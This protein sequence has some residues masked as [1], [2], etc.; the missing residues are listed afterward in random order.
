MSSENEIPNEF[1]CP[2]TLEIMKEPMVMPDGH[3]Y[4][5]EAIKKALEVTHVSPLTKIPMNF[6]DGVINYSLKSLIECYVKEHNI[7]LTDINEKIKNLSFSN[8]RE[9]E[10]IEFE[11]LFSRIITK[12]KSSGL[13][14]DSLHV[15]MKPKK[16]RTTSPVCLI[17]VVDISGSMQANCCNNVKNMENQYISRLELIK[18]SLKTI[19]ASL[20]K[21]DMFSVITFNG[22]SHI[23][24]K[25]TVLIDKNAKESVINDINSMRAFGSTNIWCGIKEAI[26]VS[27][28]I[29]FKNYRKSIM[30]FTDGDSNYNPPNGV[31]Q[32]LKDTLKIC[33]DNFTISTFS[34][35]NDAGPELLIDIANLGN[36]I[37]G[38]CSDGTMV[39]TIFINYMANLLSTITPIVKVNVTQGNDVKKT[40]TIGP[41]YR[42]TY[43]NAIF[44]IDKKLLD[45]TKVKVELPMN[46]QIIEV[47]IIKESSDL[48]LYMDEMS[49]KESKNK[50]IDNNELYSDSDSDD[51][52][53]D[54]DDS[55]PEINNA[56]ENIE[57]VNT[58]VIIEETGSEPIKYEEQLLNQILRNK[59]VIVLNKIIKLKNISYDEEE[60][61]KAKKL[62]DEYVTIIT[63][64]K[65][66]TKYAKNLL[67]DITNPDP[68]HGQV[69]KAISKIYYDTWGK[70]YINSFLRFHQY[71]QCG[72][73]KDQSLQYYS[74]EV[75]KSYRKM[76][77]TLFV[78]LPPPQTENVRLN[79]DVYDNSSMSTNTSQSRMS[80][81]SLGNSSYRSPPKSSG[82]SYSLF[83]N[84]SRSGNGLLSSHL[85]DLEE[86]IMSS[87]TDDVV[88]SCSV[89]ETQRKKGN[90]K[91]KYFINRHGGCFNG[92]SIVLLAN[93]QS[94]RVKDLKKGDR[95]NN[96]AIV[97]CLIEQTC[98]KLWKPYMCDI[99]G[100]L[101]T[102]YHPIAIDNTWYFPY[103]L[104]KSKEVT[105]DSWYNLI[106]QDDINQKYEIEF[107]NGIKAI[108]LGHNRKE[109][110]ILKHPYFGSELVL[111]DLQ[112]R[113]PIGYFKGYILI[114]EFN[115][116]NLEYD[117]NQNCINYYK[118]QNVNNDFIVI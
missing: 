71:E 35:G 13:C 28:S 38:Y 111:K 87:V 49:E 6:S 18:H 76:A 40:M 61:K 83:C 79:Y 17:C 101:F 4:E 118:I 32:T 3:T 43:R 19:V 88:D 63:D 81:R 53:L 112:E 58:D 50:I 100:V 54:S 86:P 73:F 60:N 1:I 91:M 31:Y 2:I 41:L 104:V 113:D 36:G 70:C 106:L 11:E 33:K 21:E 110:S 46:N 90:V 48:K 59:F 66:K 22:E 107:C 84:S 117:K 5:K 108:T 67:I 8:V 64:L 45:Q 44:K 77:N 30:V 7:Q 74:H 51:E 97:Q 29:S 12:D 115:F 68:N 78:N 96:G 102:P 37:Y 75:F 62:L 27:K 98:N 24:I 42:A 85:K 72:N 116:G 95:L 92:D 94:R 9:A 26:D 16:V 15:Y 93:G 103:D 69:E 52:I 10:K 65:Y 20:R 55:D 57:K 99:N 80:F 47:P 23:H 25:P 56:I 89:G 105:I 82:R 39:G 114:K 14:K 109:N 34:F